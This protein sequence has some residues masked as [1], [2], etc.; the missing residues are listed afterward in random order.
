MD[1]LHRVGEGRGGVGVSAAVDLQVLHLRHVDDAEL[2][3]PGPVGVEC[4]L[5][6]DL[7][8]HHASDPRAEGR[9][10]VGLRS[11]TA[12]NLWSCRSSCRAGSRALTARPRSEEHTS[13]LQSLMRTSYAVFC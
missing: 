1:G 3:A 2:T 6:V 9:S 8:R 11:R 13:E 5:E 12:L 10:T 4:L 7:V